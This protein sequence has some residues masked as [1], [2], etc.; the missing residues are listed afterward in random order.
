MAE[1]VTPMPKPITSTSRSSG[2]T[3]NGKCPTILTTLTAS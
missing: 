3:K 2:R 1:V